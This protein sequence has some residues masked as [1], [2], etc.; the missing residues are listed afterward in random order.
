[1]SAAAPP[2]AD[3]LAKIAEVLNEGGI[4]HLL[5]R[6][7]QKVSSPL[8][9]CGSVIFFMRELDEQLPQPRTAMEVTVRNASPVDLCLLV[10]A[11]TTVSVNALYDRFR[12]GD[13]CFIA[14]DDEGKVVHARWVTTKQ[15]YIPELGTELI[16]RPGEVYFY[17]SYTRPD[18]RGRGLDGV[19]R[20]FIYDWLGSAGFKRGYSYV[21][22][23]NPI[24]LR[25][26]RRWT[27][28]VGRLWYLRLPGLGRLVFGRRGLDLPVLGETAAAGWIEPRW[29][30]QS[31][32]LACLFWKLVQESYV[33]GR[34]I[35]C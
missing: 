32:V 19:M 8:L 15:G 13:L 17:D 3:P 28:A 18:S 27:R 5:K 30:F 25:A 7:L 2:I 20:R 12:H 26:A 23:D 6:V 24:S 22:G 29:A 1:M 16:L 31:G 21:C 14:Q 11:R 33:Y 10:E 9:E 34:S 35:G 4:P